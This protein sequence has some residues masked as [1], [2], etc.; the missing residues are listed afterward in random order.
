MCE[1][2]CAC[3]YM[4]MCKYRDNYCWNLY[5]F[6]NTQHVSFQLILIKASLCAKHTWH[7]CPLHTF[8]AQKPEVR[9]CS[10]V[11]PLVALHGV[12]CPVLGTVCNKLSF[13]WQLSLPPSVGLTIPE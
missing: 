6:V 10:L 2:V 5:L 12:A 9:S 1:N 7:L 8:S 13:Q 3:E 4:Q 11:L